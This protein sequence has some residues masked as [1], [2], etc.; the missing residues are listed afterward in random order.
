MYAVGQSKLVWKWAI[1]VNW[2]HL[3]LNEMTNN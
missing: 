1:P 2:S 3:Q